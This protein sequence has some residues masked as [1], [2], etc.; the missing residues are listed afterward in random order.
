MAKEKKTKEV[1]VV[2]G[3]SKELL[4][5]EEQ[6][7]TTE[8]VGEI[9]VE[10]TT[11]TVTLVENKISVEDAKQ[12]LAKGQEEIPFK[13]VEELEKH[14]DN[15]T[16]AHIKAIA[17]TVIEDKVLDNL[18]PTESVTP[19]IAKEEVEQTKK[20]MKEVVQID[21]TLSPG[22]LKWQAY[23]NMT[24]MSP[25]TFLIKYPT[26]VSRMFIK[27]IIEKSK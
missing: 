18:A 13:T 23:L 1:D 12:I 16:L 10:K 7:N 26:H 11:E 14:L 4:S 21:T 9:S 25:E 17:D 3:V 5:T 22:A 27:E 19:E 6:A 15:E 20:E 2:P 24:K 8:Q